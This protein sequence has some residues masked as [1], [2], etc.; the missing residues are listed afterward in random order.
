MLV[1]VLDFRRLVDFTS[2]VLVVQYLSTCV[3]VVVLRRRRPDL[4]RAVRLPLGPAIPLVGA[5]L[6][7]YVL[8]QATRVEI[9]LAV[10]SQAVG[11]IVSFLHRRRAARV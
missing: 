5:A 9:A 11:E 1:A 4:A 10:A 3:S 8:A 7:L 2:V 6:L